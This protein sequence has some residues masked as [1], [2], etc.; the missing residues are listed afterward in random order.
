MGKVS[1]KVCCKAELHKYTSIPPLNN[2]DYKI[3]ETESAKR[4]KNNIT[5]LCVYISLLPTEFKVMYKDM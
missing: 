3:K 2:F 5:V 1:R 4:K